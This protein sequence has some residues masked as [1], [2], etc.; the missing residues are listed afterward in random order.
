MIRS[1]TFRFFKPNSRTFLKNSISVVFSLALFQ[2]SQAEGIKILQ[3]HKV[4]RAP[5]MRSCL[6]YDSVCAGDRLWE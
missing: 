2:F 5:G 6:P 1:S 4:S 3:L